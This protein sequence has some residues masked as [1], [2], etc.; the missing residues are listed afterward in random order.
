MAHSRSEP[1]EDGEVAEDPIQPPHSLPPSGITSD[2]IANVP[3]K[4]PKRGNNPAWLELL[5]DRYHSAG[6]K[7]KYSGDARFWSTY[8]PSHKEYRPLDNP[9]PPNSSYHKYGGL[10]ARLELVDA[11]VCF[12]YSL[13]CKD[14][15]RKACN[16]QT[17]ST[18]EAFLVW[19]K[20]KWEPEEGSNDAEKAFCGLIYMIEGF[21]HARKVAYSSR[22]YL[23]GEIDKLVNTA[24]KS[25]QQAISEAESGGG[26]SALLG[27]KPQATP[28]M[29]PSPASIVPTN[30]ANSTPTNRDGTPSSSNT[31]SASS[32]SSSAPPAHEVGPAIPARLLP[33]P[34]AQI[35]F[36]GGPVP[37]HI[38][39]A[40]NK[41]SIPVSLQIIGAIKDQTGGINAAADR[42][43]T[44]QQLLTLPIMARHFPKTFARMIHSTLS[45][46]EEH[47]PDIEDEEGELS[48]PGQCINGE[49]L[50]WVCLMGQAMIREFGKAYGYKGLKGVVPKPSVESHRHHLPQRSGPHGST[51][52]SN[53]AQR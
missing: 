26:N 6:R 32:A 17:W 21:I 19:C 7:L 35:A 9:P 47:E 18:I 42:L 39:A 46:T 45:S 53:S 33:R 44:A 3:I 38:T 11:L 22:T 48:W 13:W 14:Y 41:V 30:S 28:P 2:A 37:P 16:P 43:N 4:R 24:R 50:G 36:Q 52:A 27:G 5:H 15:S 1:A 10:I 34:Y 40:A 8:P 31:R 12:T 51:P 49:G 25:T 20:S 23:D 29:L